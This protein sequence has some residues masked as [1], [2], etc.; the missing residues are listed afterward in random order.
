V[1]VKRIEGVESVDV[2]LN[3][4]LAVI[5]LKPG[6][7][8]DLER[9]REAIRDNGFT[10]RDASVRVAG[11]VI[12]RDGKPALA[13]PGQEVPFLLTDHPEARGKA[14]ELLRA[15]RDRTVVVEGRVS[16]SRPSEHGAPPLEIR[17]FS[18]PGG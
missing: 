7:H 12:E 5:R 14:D 1:A 17:S 3:R 16:T 9:V 6:N 4:G 13:V 2:S 8:V 18:L 15:A 11:R 10:P